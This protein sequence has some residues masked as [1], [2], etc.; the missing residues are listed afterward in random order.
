MNV[1]CERALDPQ[2]LLLEDLARILTT[3]GL[4]S[5]TVEMLQTDI[6]EGAPRNADGTVNLVQYA[7]WLVKE[8]LRGD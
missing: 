8:L 5:T 4:R 3:S 2:A 7:A 6:D 1:T